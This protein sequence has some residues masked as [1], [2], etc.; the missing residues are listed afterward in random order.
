MDL[1]IQAATQ[2][3]T[4]LTLLCIVLGTAFGVVVGVLPGLGS[5]IG[6]TMVLPFTFGL[7]QVPAIALMLGVYCGSVYGG[8]ITATILNTPGTPQSAATALEGFPMAMRGEASLAIGWITMS[9]MIGG[10]FSV[11]VLIIVGPALARFSLMFTP[12]E[13][14]ALGLFALTCIAGVSAG[15]LAKGLMGGALGV[16]IA[17]IGSDPVTGT[18]RFTFDSF[19][20]TAGIGLIPVVV[21][22]FA[23]SE[24]F[25]RIL[26]LDEPGMDRTTMKVGFSLP[27]WSAWRS[28]IGMLV[29]GSLI[30]SFVGALPG[31]GAA[32]ASFIA[33]SEARRTSKRQEN[34]GKGEPDGIVACESANNAVTGSALVPTLSLGIPGDPVTAVMLGALVIQGIAPGPQLFVNHMDIVYALFMA[35][36]LVNVVM[37]GVGALGASVFTRILRVPEPIL[38]GLIMII[39]TLGAYGVS[40]STFDVWIAFGAG[41][42]GA[43]LRYFAFPVAPIVIGLVLGPMLELSLRQ[44]LILTRGSFLA[45]LERPIAL[46]LFI[47]TALVLLWPLLRWLRSRR[48][49]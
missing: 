12:I 47:I 31:T 36:I 42:L 48:R 46:V 19:M 1:L 35:L 5:V 11:T 26:K 6:L 18:L 27:P 41:V 15:A 3:A 40:G 7:P 30:G 9:S 16:L 25:L 32:T 14:F 10:L 20:L 2:V 23:F 39:S 22:L 29:R 38:I 37:F 34:F 8:S 17:T 28:R 24:M 21:G 44:G 43:L 4:P 45:F 13:Y 33:Y 49:A